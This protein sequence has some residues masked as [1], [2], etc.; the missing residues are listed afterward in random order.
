MVL[1][2]KPIQQTY[3][4]TCR[5]NAKLMRWQGCL[6]NYIFQPLLKDSM[7]SSAKILSLGHSLDN[8]NK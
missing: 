6:K 8:R 1:H 3:S 2:S 7:H 4:N 5:E